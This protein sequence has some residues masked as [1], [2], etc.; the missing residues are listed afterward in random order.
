MLTERDESDWA[1]AKRQLRSSPAQRA[2]AMVELGRQVR[3]TQIAVAE[4]RQ[5][6]ND[7]A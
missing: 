3:A 5:A 7:V 6:K 2:E 4:S 1:Q